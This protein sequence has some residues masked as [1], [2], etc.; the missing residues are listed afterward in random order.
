MKAAPASVQ[1]RVARLRAEI[2]RHNHRYHV[3]YDPE[4]S[5]AEYDRL[6]TEL[7]S[8]EADYPAR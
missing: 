8:V 5:D 4:V 7:R 1:Q 3:L 2:N 6:L